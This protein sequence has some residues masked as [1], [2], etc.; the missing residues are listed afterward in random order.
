MDITVINITLVYIK[1]VHN[2]LQS[3]R[4]ANNKCCNIITYNKKM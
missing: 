2:N 1:T 4:L 3:A